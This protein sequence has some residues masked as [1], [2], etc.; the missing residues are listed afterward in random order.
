MIKFT[1]PKDIDEVLLILIKTYHSVLQNRE[2]FRSSLQEGLSKK[3][4]AAI[5]VFY[6]AHDLGVVFEE[7]KDVEH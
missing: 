3:E 4:A 5:A 6:T 7:E 1:N 2:C